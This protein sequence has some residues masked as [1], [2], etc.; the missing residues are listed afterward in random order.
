MRALAL[1][2]VL[3]TTAA[4]DQKPKIIFWNMS[5]PTVDSLVRNVPQ[6]NEL[7]LRQLAQTFNDLEC[8][9]SHLREH[10]VG[11]GK[12]L[13]C[14]LPGNTGKTILFVAHYEHE[15]MGQ[16]AIDNWTGA[17]MLPFL[18]HAMAAAPREHT[19]LFAEI[20]GVAGAKALLASLRS[21]GLDVK[22]VVALDALGLGPAQFYV[23]PSD[24]PLSHAADWGW[25][26][27]QLL[28]AAI[29]RGSDAPISSIPGGWLK[30]DDT[31]EFRHRLIPSILIHSVSGNTR[32]IPGS[33]LDTAA[34]IDA[35]AYFNAYSLLCYY[36]AELDQ[37]PPSQNPTSS[38]P[39]NR[40]VR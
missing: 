23:N 25:M 4:T 5:R 30:I 11:E 8:S 20:D 27:R 28:Q 39:S 21:D 16:S 9:G 26:Q 13:L 35:D 3:L 31:R 32:H 19:F 12:N 37:S 18:Y 36:I 24:A 33:A 2:L 40:H 17:M 22:T 14:T 1:T 15:G 34:A 6:S 38:P 10:P 29:D 7:R